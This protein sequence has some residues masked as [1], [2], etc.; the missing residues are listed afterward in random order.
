M[1]GFFAH[2]QHFKAAFTRSAIAAPLPWWIETGGANIRQTSVASWTG[3]VVWTLGDVAMS[4][5]PLGHLYDSAR[6]G[7]M[8]AHQLQ[9]H[10]L[11]KYC[12]ELGRVTPATIVDHIEP[13]K[14]D[15]NKFWLGKLQSL[16]D[17][18]HTGRRRLFSRSTAIGRTSAWTAGRSTSGIRST[19]T[20]ARR[21]R[22]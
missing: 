21:P 6:W 11:C 16:C 1:S 5:G 9:L 15:V 14:G 22:R 12:A 18:C 4:I 13:H 7:R 2:F 17:A 3:A 20:N 8:R 10:P 19:G